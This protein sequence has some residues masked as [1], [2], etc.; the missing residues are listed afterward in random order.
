[1]YISCWSKYKEDASHLLSLPEAPEKL[2]IYDAELEKPESFEAVI[3][4]CVSVFHLSHPMD[5]EGTMSNYAIIKTTIEGNLGVLQA[6]LKSK[7]VKKLVYTSS[8][9]EAVF[10]HKSGVIKSIF[11][12]TSVKLIFKFFTIL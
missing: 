12:S 11:F 9:A 2:Q 5:F 4:G 1:M 3:N 6:C 8:I 7:I 10:I